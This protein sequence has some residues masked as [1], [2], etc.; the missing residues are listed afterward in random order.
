M[1]FIIENVEG[2]ED[3]GIDTIIVTYEV[4]INWD[5]DYRM[6]FMYGDGTGFYGYPK[7]FLEYKKRRDAVFAEQE[8][9]VEEEEDFGTY[10]RSFDIVGPSYEGQILTPDGITKDSRF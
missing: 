10:D 5:A 3:L 1:K 4:T 6:C 2:L 8:Y 7:E 9:L